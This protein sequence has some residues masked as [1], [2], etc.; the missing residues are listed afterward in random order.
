MHR[1]VTRYRWIPTTSRLS[2]RR[3][4][5]SAFR[6]SRRGTIAPSRRIRS[7][8]WSAPGRIYRTAL[9]A[10]SPWP[11]S[12]SSTPSL[13]PSATLK[14]DRSDIFFSPF[15][16]FG[17]LRGEP[18]I[19]RLFDYPSFSPS[20]TGT[21]ATDVLDSLALGSPPRSIIR[22][23]LSGSDNRKIED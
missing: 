5:C 13:T 12:R 9:Y 17:M 7:R 21:I 14:T 8:L 3:G 22:Q 15:P 20:A 23:H 1:S 4:R 18:S 11:R 10:I 2:W 19:I 6:C 16:Q